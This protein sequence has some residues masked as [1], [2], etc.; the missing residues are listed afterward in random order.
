MPIAQVNGI[1][2]YYEEFG[3]GDNVIISA[4]MNFHPEDYTEL[5]SREPFNYKV[6][7]IQLRGYGKSTHVFE[8]LGPQL[9][10][11][12]ADDVYEFARQKGVDRF[13]YT[14]VSHGGGVGW[15]I[16]RKY[17]EALKAFVSIV[18]VP[19]DRRG[20]DSSE[21]RR[22]TVSFASDPQKMA[23]TLREK[24]LLYQVPTDNP[25]RLARREQARDRSIRQFAS[26]KPE[27]L[28]LNQRKP[29]PEAETN[30]QLM[31]ILSQI[32][33]PTLMLC[34]VQD[35]IISAEISFMAAKSVPKSKTVFYQDHSH[36]L[37]GESPERV[38]REIDLFIKELEDG[39]I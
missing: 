4:Q 5:L 16:A 22:R 20:G 27:E 28:R 36:T 38:A 26:M 3:S 31:E 33:G 29:F 6:Y 37:S 9:L 24:P 7:Q 13:I 8:D 35:D 18:G 30:E 34:G 14:G 17:P 12:W 39:L 21:A 25:K 23:E 19:H 32:K 10:H 2:L 15:Y 11:L 1:E